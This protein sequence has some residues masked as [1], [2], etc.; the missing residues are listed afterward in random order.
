MIYPSEFIVMV[1]SGSIGDSFLWIQTSFN[2]SFR[3]RY[4]QV[5]GIYDRT[6]DMFIPKQPYDSWTLDVNNEWQP[7]TAMPLDGKVYTW[8][9]ANQEW[10][11]VAH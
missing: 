9:E 4:A 7:P 10:D 3:Q 2:N 8:D 6:I 11:Y 5:D 1:N